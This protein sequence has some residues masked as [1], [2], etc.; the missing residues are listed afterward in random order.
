MVESHYNEL[1]EN[2]MKEL[3]EL[4]QEIEKLIKSIEQNKDNDN[5]QLVKQLDNKLS[6][7]IDQHE[8]LLPI[9][10]TMRK[11]DVSLDI[12]LSLKLLFINQSTNKILDSGMKLIDS[13]NNK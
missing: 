4:N 5:Q 9:I 6:I 12:D 8:K 10:S 2:K 7:L 11:Y 13:L 1:I 3:N